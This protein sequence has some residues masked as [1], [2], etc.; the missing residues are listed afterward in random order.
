MHS[1][2]LLVGRTLQEDLGLVYLGYANTGNYSHAVVTL[3]FRDIIGGQV[4]VLSKNLQYLCK[5]E[6][7]GSMSCV[8]M[9]S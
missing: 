7:D 5:C 4:E 2:Q 8:L 9:S 1:Q 3:S 6:F